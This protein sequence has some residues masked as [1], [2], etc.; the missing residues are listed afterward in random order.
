MRA[1]ILRHLPQIDDDRARRADGRPR[2]RGLGARRRGG[3]PRRG[4]TTAA[5]TGWS[6]SSSRSRVSCADATAVD[7]VIRAL[8]DASVALKST[9]GTLAATIEGPGR[10]PR[11][12]PPVPR[13]PRRRPLPGLRQEGRA[14]PGVARPPGEGGEGAPR[15]RARRHAGP[16]GRR[17]RA[18]ARSASCPRRGPTL[19]RQ[20]AEVGLDGG[21]VLRRL[22][23]W[24]K[25]LSQPALED[26]GQ[27]DGGRGPRRCAPPSPISRRRP[28]PRSSAARTP[29]ARSR[30]R[31]T[32]GCPS[33]ATARD[34]ADAIKPL[35]AAEAWLK[36]AVADIRTQRSRPSRRSA[37]P[38][39]PS[40]ASRAT[41]RW[42]TSASRAPPRSG[43]SSWT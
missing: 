12:G 31:S 30:R 11:P 9:A 36:D 38:S 2:A 6:A 7:I 27:G 39:G 14:R 42:R 41:S 22:E 21:D 18:P 25:A 24:Q 20:A 1:N 29:G 17:Q 33:P 43:R 23:A 32:P 8:R 40:S 5:R 35:K 34:G 28:R 19:V 37:R 15:R 16:P 26:A 10:R 13:A 4:P 3:D